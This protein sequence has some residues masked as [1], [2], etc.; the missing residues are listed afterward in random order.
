[1]Q[2]P[3]TNGPANAESFWVQLTLEEI[4]AVR[5]YRSKAGAAAGRKVP[6]L[7]EEFLQ[8]RHEISKKWRRMLTKMLGRFAQQF[9]GPIE[10][11]RAPEVQDWIGTLQDN[12]TS[13]KLGPRSRNN[14]RNAIRELATWARDERKLLPK[15]WDELDGLRKEKTRATVNLYTPEEIAQL[16]TAAA[17]LKSGL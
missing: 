2:A 1:M 12:R 7:V 15:T 4:K 10:A 9:A 8:E 6:E 5:D 14:Y 17:T 16:L 11:L 13:E 3:E